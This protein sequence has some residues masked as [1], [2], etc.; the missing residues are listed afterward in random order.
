MV[1]TITVRKKELEKLIYYVYMFTCNC[2]DCPAF[3]M[4]DTYKTECENALWGYL[5]KG[6]K[7]YD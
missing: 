6:I 2:S 4:C 1:D 5:L 3:D 7:N